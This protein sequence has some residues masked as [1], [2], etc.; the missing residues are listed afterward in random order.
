MDRQL[1]QLIRAAGG[2]GEKRK[3]QSTE[4]MEKNHKK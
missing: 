2:D 4:F 3:N 1:N